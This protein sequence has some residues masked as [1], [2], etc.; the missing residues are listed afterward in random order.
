M[1]FV[2]GSKGIYYSKGIYSTVLETRR[3]QNLKASA[4]LITLEISTAEWSVTSRASLRPLPSGRGIA[5]YISW[6]KR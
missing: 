5:C 2:S 3:N 1:V 4:K 6:E